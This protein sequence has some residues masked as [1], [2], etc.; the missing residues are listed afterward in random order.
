MSAAEYNRRVAEL[1]GRGCEQ[2]KMS[3]VPGYFA[4]QMKPEERRKVLFELIGGCDGLSDAEIVRDNPEL[5]DLPRILGKR[6]VEDWRKVAA[7]TRKRLNRD[8]DAIPVRLD[9]LA[10]QV[11]DSRSPADIEREIA[12][13]E[14]AQTDPNAAAK[15]ELAKARDD[16]QRQIGEA[17]ATLCAAINAASAESAT[18]PVWSVGRGVAACG[19]DV[20]LNTPHWR[21]ATDD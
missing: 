16:Y 12:A 19:R 8:L 20:P 21:L 1:T 7:E 2:V 15:A 10:G 3:L 18:M 17:T 4:E 5:C 9:E 6:S 13:A 11:K 14:S